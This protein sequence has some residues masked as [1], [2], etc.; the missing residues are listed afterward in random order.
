MRLTQYLTEAKWT[1]TWYNA[2]MDAKGKK[3]YSHS[4]DKYE[5]VPTGEHP[6]KGFNFKGSGRFWAINDKTT[7]RQLKPTH[8]TLAKAKSFAEKL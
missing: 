6:T 4:N 8:M 1:K 5:I 2:M 3:I 7:G